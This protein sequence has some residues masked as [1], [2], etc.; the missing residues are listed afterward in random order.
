VAYVKEHADM[1]LTEVGKHFGLSQGSISRIVRAA[2]QGRGHRGRPL[3][4]RHRETDEQAYWEQRLH[5]AGLGM[6]RGLRIRNKRIIYGY[7]PSVAADG[8]T[9]ANEAAF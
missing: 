1:P 2:G 6:D 3:K 9:L 4:R 5:D 8:M 7:N